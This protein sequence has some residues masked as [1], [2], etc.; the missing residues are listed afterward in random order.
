MTLTQRGTGIEIR[1]LRKAFGQVTAIDHLDLDIHPGEFLA[2]LGPSGSGKS[3]VL[4]ALAG[5]EPPT[6]GTIRIDGEDCTHVPPHRRNIGMVFQHYTLFPHMSVL[7]NVAFPLRMRGVAKE[8][9]RARAAA[10]LETVRLGAFGDRLPKQLSGGQQQRVAIARAIVYNPRVLLMDEPLSALDKNLRE[11]MQIEIKRLQESLGI[12]VVFVTHD[13]GEALTMADRVAIL[14][15]GRLQQIS[16]ARELYERPANLFAA[17]FIGEMNQLNA[18]YDGARAHFSDGTS[19]AVP[20]TALVAPVPPGPAT[21]TIRPERVR[22]V[23]PG[24]GDLQGVVR[25]VIYSGAGTLIIAELP[26]GTEFRARISSAG[27]APP[28]AGAPLGFA[29]PPEGLLLYPA[30]A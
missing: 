3:T 14:Q 12:T 25:D 2:L 15:S 16:P 21:L 27:I 30:A 8:E 19:L 1:G 26:G 23:A 20:Q 10:A 4:M 17:G 18:R 24:S 13:Q 9:R 5:F 29:L 22:P 7:D 6:G 11:E 28:A